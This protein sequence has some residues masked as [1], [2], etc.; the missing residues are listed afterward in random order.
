MRLIFSLIALLFVSLVALFTAPV[1]A[2]PLVFI[3]PFAVAL[4]LFAGTLWRFIRLR[5]AMARSLLVCGIF[6]FLLPTMAFAAESGVTTMFGFDV[7]TFTLLLSGV[8]TVATSIFG[9]K[10]SKYYNV[11][12]QLTSMVEDG[13]VSKEE[14]QKFVKALKNL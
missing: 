8:L 2:S 9:T 6:L 4:C 12:K 10:L 11:L 1:S 14:L 5:S 7:Q 3:A 13:N